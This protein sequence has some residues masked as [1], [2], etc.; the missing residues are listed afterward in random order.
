M[1]DIKNKILDKIPEPWRERANLAFYMAM[2]VTVFFLFFW[3][4]QIDG[5]SMQDTFNSGD[6]VIV[7]RVYS[8]FS[9]AR[10]DVV[11]CRL[12][13]DGKKTNLI[14]RVVGIPN[15]HL[16][17]SGGRVYIDDEILWEDYK[18][19]PETYGDIEIYLNDN[20]YF[21]MG[22]DRKLS[23]D[24]RQLGVVP[25]KNISAKVLFKLFLPSL[26]LN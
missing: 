15:E 24:S 5:S 1:K 22:D 10:G 18:K 11:L 7:S 25:R 6:L 12:D 26:S 21:V 4:L 19:Y 20:E 17:I 13:V 3:P 9:V 8:R 2:V 16:K 23:Q 14:K